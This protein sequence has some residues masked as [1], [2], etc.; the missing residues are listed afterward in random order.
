MAQKALLFHDADTY[1][2]IMASYSPMEQKKLGR[3]V[4]NY[5]DDVWKSQRYEIVLNGNKAKFS[6]NSALHDYL[7]LTGDAILAEASPKDTIWGIG[8]AKDHPDAPYP[9]RWPGR[10]L[11]G[12][13]LMEARD[14]LRTHF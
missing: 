9:E 14:W 13:A 10:N 5:E 2:Q 11:L 1:H 12:F 3:K 8:L 4:A 6:Q 7:L